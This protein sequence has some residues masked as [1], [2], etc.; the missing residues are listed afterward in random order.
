MTANNDVG[1]CA[2]MDCKVN[3]YGVEVRRQAKTLMM[4]DSIPILS[5]FI[6]FY[7][8]K[9]LF[10]VDQLKHR[11]TKTGEKG[12]N[13]SCMVDP[14]TA[15]AHIHEGPPSAWLSPR[16]VDAYRPRS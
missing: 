13:P 10:C 7:H 5:R 2:A 9:S 14:P 16:V 1:N 11:N 15:A 8:T 4:A 12:H 3:N 6:P